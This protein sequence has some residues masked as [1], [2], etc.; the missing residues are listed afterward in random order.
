[1]TDLEKASNDFPVEVHMSYGK[2][3]LSNIGIIL[4]KDRKGFSMVSLT[5]TENGERLGKCDYKFNQVANSFFPD[6][7]DFNLLKEKSPEYR[8]YLDKLK[9]FYEGKK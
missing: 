4:K 2:T 3:K 9:V 7:N 8:T 6:A 5:L 1:M